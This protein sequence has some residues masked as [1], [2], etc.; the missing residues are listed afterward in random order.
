[1]KDT[2][3]LKDGTVIELESSPNLGNLRV[4]AASRA[5]MLKTWEALTDGNLKTAQVKNAAGLVVGNYDGLVLESETSVVAADGSVMTTYSLREKTDIEKLA[6]RVTAMEESQEVQD[7]AIIDLG[8][9][10]SVLADQM[11]GEK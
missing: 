11:G 1:M 9:V 2:L 8:E 3:N 4:A 7:G 10:A 6:E 5:D